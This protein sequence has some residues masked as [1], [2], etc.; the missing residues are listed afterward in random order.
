MGRGWAGRLGELRQDPRRCEMAL[1]A[2]RG[3]RG[4]STAG[5]RAHDYALEGYVDDMP[6][7]WLD[8]R[9]VLQQRM[10]TDPPTDDLALEEEAWDADR[11]REQQERLRSAG[12]RIVETV[13]RHVPSG[14]IAPRL[15]DFRNWT[16]F[17]YA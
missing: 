1:P 7:E 2:V 9:A 5:V 16:A 4:A 13:A 15:S 14:R 11:L 10:S 17:S 8:D 12:R 6:T 3:A